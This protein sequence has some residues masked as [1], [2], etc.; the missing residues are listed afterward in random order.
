LGGLHQA[1]GREDVDHTL[2]IDRLQQVVDVQHRLAEELAGALLLERQE[3]ALDGA[4]RR[5]GY[6]AV[7]GLELLRIV[8][9]MLEQGAKVLEVEQQQAVVVGDLEREREHAFLRL[10]EIEDAR[11]QQRAHVG[12]VARTGWPCSPNRS[13]KVTG[14]SWNL[15]FLAPIVFKRSSSFGRLARLAQP[16]RS[17]LTSA[18]KMGT[19]IDDRRSDMTWSVTV[20][21]VPS[22]R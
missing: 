3:A 2:A 22:R 11:Q 13:Q 5:R 1:I 6:V 10:V 9:N 14:K 4:D 20:L 17:P 12:D 19:P 15:G 8:P 21:P 7:V 18:M 16:A